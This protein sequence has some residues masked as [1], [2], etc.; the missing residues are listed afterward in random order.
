MYLSPE[1]LVA[2]GIPSL[3]QADIS[4]SQFYDD[5]VFEQ[6]TNSN[7]DEIAAICPVKIQVHLYP[8]MKYY[9]LVEILLSLL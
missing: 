5:I 2:A 8:L 9:F 6:M 3:F 1:L 7:S 4:S